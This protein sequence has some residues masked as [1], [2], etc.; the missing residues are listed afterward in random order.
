MR[1]LHYK[2]MGS[3]SPLIV[4]H[5]LLGSLDNWL[6]I[7]KI[8]AEY[9]EVY[10]MDQRNHGKSF[11]SN[12]FSYEILCSDLYNFFEQHEIAKANILGHSMGGKVAMLFA[13]N[14]PDKTNHLIVSDIAPVDYADKHTHILKALTAIDLSVYGTRQEIEEALRSGLPGEDERVIQFLMKGLYRNELNQ[15]AWRYNVNAIIDAYDDISR[16]EKP[17]GKIFWGKTLFI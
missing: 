9:F 4:L 13:L 3:G 1:E 2:K 16:F 7:G 8:L 17:K 12:E 6:S 15:F 14:Y 5:G 11:H 10:L